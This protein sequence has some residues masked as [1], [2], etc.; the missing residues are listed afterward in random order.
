[1]AKRLVKFLMGIFGGLLTTTFSKYVFVFILSLMPILE[2]RGGLIASAIL[3]LNPVWSYIICIIS[4]IISF[5][6]YYCFIKKP[7]PSR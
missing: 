5:F 2:L 7:T 6:H 4:N 3:D 1:M